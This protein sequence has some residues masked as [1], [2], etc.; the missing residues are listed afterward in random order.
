MLPTL[1]LIAHRE[2]GAFGIL[3]VVSQLTRFSVIPD[4]AGHAV[5]RRMSAGGQCRVA[6]NGLGI[7]MLIVRVC[8]H[9]T[10]IQQVTKATLTKLPLATCEKIS[11][12]A[13]HG[14]LQHQSNIRVMLTST[15][16]RCSQNQDE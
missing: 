3:N 10:V 1:L 4:I 2:D 5:N 15:N 6:Y 16:G 12:Q 13:I 14:E 9:S 8:K 11:P 7:G